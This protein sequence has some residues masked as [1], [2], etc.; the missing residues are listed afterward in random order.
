MI[1]KLTQDQQ[2]E[3]DYN[4]MIEDLLNMREQHN[5]KNNSY[6]NNLYI[7]LDDLFNL[8]EELEELRNILENGKSS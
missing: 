2:D 5:I 1:I 8:K 7:I 6:Y 4:I 3:L